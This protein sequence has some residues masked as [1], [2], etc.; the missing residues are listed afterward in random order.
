MSIPVSI[1]QQGLKVMCVIVSLVMVSEWAVSIFGGKR[2]S[3]TPMSH[4]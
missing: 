2:P 4:F 3:R 1:T